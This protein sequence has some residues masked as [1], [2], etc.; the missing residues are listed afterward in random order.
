MSEI[1]DDPRWRESEE[2]TVRA[3]SAAADR[4][5]ARAMDLYQRAARLAEEFALSIDAT[6]PRTRS[7]AAVSAVVLAARSG[8][9]NHAV[10]LA[11]QFLAS[12][13]SLREDGLAE[14]GALRASYLRTIAASAVTPS[15]PSSLGSSLQ[16]SRN[17]TRSYFHPHD[18]SREA[19]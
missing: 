6:M 10:R 13:G 14:L 16:V 3:E 12:P 5:L 19:A 8:D 9:F 15:R 11:E 18:S 1:F 17:K 4:D 7:I 2:L